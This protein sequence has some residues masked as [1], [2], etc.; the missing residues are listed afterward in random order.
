MKFRIRVKGPGS[1]EWWEDEDREVGPQESVR[2]HGRLPNFTGDIDQW[3]L[4][5]VAWFNKDAA[6]DRQRTFI[7][8]EML[9]SEDTK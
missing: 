1:D 2:G 3:G 6:H 8:A 7:R 5:I 9:D 4:D